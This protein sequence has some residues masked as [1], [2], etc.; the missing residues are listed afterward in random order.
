MHINIQ[1]LISKVEELEVYLDANNV[2]ILCISEHWLRCKINSIGNNFINMSTFCRTKFKNGGV[3]IFCRQNIFNEIKVINLNSTEKEFECAAIEYN[4]TIILTVY[5]SPASCVKYFLS[6]LHDTLLSL[7]DINKQIILTGDFNIDLLQPSKEVEELSRVIKCFGLKFNIFTPTR[8]TDSSATCIDNVISDI[9]FKSVHCDEPGLSDHKAQLVTFV[10]SSKSKVNN[11]FF[12]TIKRELSNENI[13]RLRNNLA[14]EM[15]GEVF[16]VNDTTLDRYNIFRDIFQY[17]V[18]TACPQ[19]KSKIFLNKKNKWISSGI[20]KSAETLKQLRKDDTN[21]KNK[22]FRKYF[23]IY[24]RTYRRVIRAAKRQYYNS[25]IDSATNKSKA[26]WSIIKE[27]TGN[28][29]GDGFGDGSLQLKDNGSVIS[30]PSQV[31]DIFS[32]HFTG[33]S[34]QNINDLG[35]LTSHIPIN[36]RTMFL[37]PATEAEIREI[38][39]GIKSK[40][41]QGLDGIPS[42][43]IRQCCDS[44]ASPLCYLVNQSFASGSFPTSLKQALVKPIFKKGEK[45]LVD[46]YRPISILNSFSK[47]YEKAFANR[48]LKFLN[49]FGILTEN[50][51]GFRKDKSVDTALFELVQCLFKKLDSKEFPLSIFCDLT[52]AFDNVNHDILLGKL[53]IYGIRGVALDW[54]RSYLTDRTQRVEIESRM[55]V[56]ITKHFSRECK[57]L[58]GVPQGSVLGPLLFL[59]YINDLPLL[60][61]HGHTTLFA[62]DTTVTVSS[63]CPIDSLS[64]AEEDIGKLMQWTAM[65]QLQLNP[66]KS[67]FLTYKVSDED[68]VRLSINDKDI[69]EKSESMKFLGVNI[70]YDM[71]WELHINHVANKIIP[72]CYGLLRTSS[73]LNIAALKSIYYGYIHSNLKYGI[74]CWGN[75]TNSKKLFTLQKRALRYIAKLG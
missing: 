32:S 49:K 74:I 10:N 30:N 2:D 42:S 55:N 43:V 11:K 22:E 59:V 12:V 66:S 75:S 7:Y 27:Q 44:I 54:I 25:Q 65:N 56:N 19:I 72:Y 40:T 28:P 60:L 39:A 58:K 73:T 47:I 63:K 68:N 53:Q 24:K 46:N 35:N 51:H 31:A 34:P 62:D 33:L 61:K 18:N 70:S 36:N 14:N 48:L 71:K 16:K 57:V 64:K 50:Q 1:S 23:Q 67:C 3:A 17:H 45:N 4:K 69:I 6:K 9:K 13:A 37:Y 5:R 8:I 21:Y 20:R 38:I 26:M 29:S 15:W 41:S 52:K